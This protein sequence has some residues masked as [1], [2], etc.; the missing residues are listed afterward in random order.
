MLTVNMVVS[1]YCNRWKT[2][3]NNNLKAMNTFLQEFTTA[4]YMEARG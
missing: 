2:G 3:W 1:K 4:T